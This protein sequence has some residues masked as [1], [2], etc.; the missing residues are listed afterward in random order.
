MP[1]EALET[2][3][4]ELEGEVGRVDSQLDEPEIWKDA[5]RAAEINARRDE[6]KAE[7][8]ALETEWLGRV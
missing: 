2:K 3:I 8:D 6:L 1:V 4:Q 7:L 5:V